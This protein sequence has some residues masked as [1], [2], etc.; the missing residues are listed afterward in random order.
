MGTNVTPPTRAASP[1]T[2]DPLATREALVEAAV[3]LFGR[4]GFHATGVQEL[5]DA[6]GLTKGAFYHHFRS[7]E[8]VL[9]LIHDRFMDVQLQRERAIL[10][11]GSSAH[12]R[13]FRLVRLSVNVIAEYLPEVR[14][15]FREYRALGSAEFEEVRAKRAAATASFR[16]I[17]REGVASGEFAAGADPDVAALGILGMCDWM[18][19][20]YAPDG[21][22]PADA[23]ACQ[24]ALMAL[25][26]VSARPQAVQALEAEAARPAAG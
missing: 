23:I 26:S 7:K 3:E 13:L 24:F 12:E 8:E 9:R 1:R 25:R 6:A 16:D 18:H 20:W 22:L 14:V 10:A 15:F 5:V 2:Y 19:Q 21:R 4:K 17:L 11:A